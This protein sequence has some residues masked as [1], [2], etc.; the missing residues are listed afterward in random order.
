MNVLTMIAPPPVTPM[1][2]LTTDQQAVAD[3]FL[4]FIL[5]TEA[6]EMVISGPA[7][8]GKTFLT[9]YLIRAAES[10]KQLLK[11]LTNKD[12]ELNLLFTATTNKAVVVME[13]ALQKSTRTIHSLLGLKVY[14]DY[15]S[16]D[17]KLSKTPNTKEIFN[18]IVFID[19]CSLIDYRLLGI[20]REMTTNCKVIYIGDQYQLLPVRCSES[21]VFGSVANQHFLST[22][23]RQ[24]IDSPIIR[25]AD[26]IKEAI[27]V[28]QGI[29]LLSDGNVVERI[30]MK[31]MK[32]LLD[33]I[34][35]DPDIH[36]NH[37]RV[38]GWTNNRVQDFNDHIRKLTQSTVEF[39]AGERVITNKPILT[40]TGM[41]VA[42]TDEILTVTSVGAISNYQGIAVRNYELNHKI[43]VYQPLD[44][45]E[46]N[47]RIKV[48]AK[49][50][51]WP[52]Y[53]NLK[54]VLSDLRAP[55]AITAHK[56]QG[57]TYNT[58]FIDLEDIGRNNKWNEVARLLYVAVTRASHKVYLVGDLP[59]RYTH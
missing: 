21:P 57:S 3:A 15:S 6:K 2:A 45:A 5:N 29:E 44:Q 48:L 20:I 31:Q 59:A 38:I 32:P 42:N 23:K 30:S 14:E 33:Q 7:G 19:E 35:T 46:A 28:K 58:V 22:I 53:F 10:Q 27:M 34:F 49:A 12:K 54:N 39:T 13:E 18:S 16:G 9:Q 55:F 52:S 17:T 40:G 26:R 11:L 37:C 43:Y 36:E 51:D 56:S 1:P 24:I 50:K 47:N 8:S 25:T 41:T 4:G